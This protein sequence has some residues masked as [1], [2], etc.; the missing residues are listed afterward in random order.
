MRL[1]P[2]TAAS[3][4]LAT[5][6]LVVAHRG[7]HDGTTPYENTLPAYE[8]AI[9]LGADLMETDVRRTA[10]GILVIYHDA[11]IQGRSI[12]NTKYAD[13]PKLPTGEPI[14]TFEQL[15]DLTARSATKTKLLVETKA[16]GFERDMVAILRARLQPGQYEL[17]SFDLDSVR[18]LRELAPSGTRVGALFGLTPDWQSGTWP[19]T[20][21][22]IVSKARAAGADFV[23]IDGTI[24]NESRLRTIAAAGLDIAIWT[25]NDTA[26][27]RRFLSDARV[28]R[29]ITDRP[30]EAMRLREEL[31]RRSTQQL[32]IAA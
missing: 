3:P 17:M 26:G 2:V 23:A 30:D 19:I 16:H 5:P 18:A 6:K 28:Q 7:Y 20:G 22:A 9:K 32:P 14:P 15:V 1:S 10:D 25:V 8:R 21:A 31:T 27:L 29:V 4:A 13:L 12:A 11:K 24:A